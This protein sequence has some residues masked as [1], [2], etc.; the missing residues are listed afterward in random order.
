MAFNKKTFTEGFIAETTENL[1]R[2]N[3][4][5]IEF[6][7]SP[8]DREKL[9]KILRLLHTIK[10]TARMIGFST[11]E[12]VTHGLEDVFKGIRE[13][14]YKL[15]DN[16]VQLTFKTTD[17][18]KSLMSQLEESGSDDADVEKILAIYEKASAGMFFSLQ[19]LNDDP[20][21]QGLASLRKKPLLHKDVCAVTAM[22]QAVL[23]FAAR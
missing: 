12:K 4:C 17:I 9:A 19:E 20:T 5:L 15:T 1:N 18:I 23:D 22:K 8:A 2:V 11:I 13:E 6:K 7:A 10:G 3:D 21:P 14:K 16:I